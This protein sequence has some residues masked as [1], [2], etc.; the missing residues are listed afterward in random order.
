MGADQLVW[1]LVRTIGGRYTTYVQFWGGEYSREREEL[2]LKLQLQI[3]ET[4][5][6]EY[7]PAVR[8]AV[9]DVSDI[10]IPGGNRELLE[11]AAVF[12]AVLHK[13]EIPIQK[14][15]SN[16]IIKTTAGGE[17]IATVDTEW[18]VSD[19]DYKQERQW[20]DYG[21]C[22]SMW[23]ESGK[24][25]AVSSWSADSRYDCRESYWAN[26]LDTDYEYLY[27]YMKGML[28]E[29][30]T[31]NLTVNPGADPLNSA[32]NPANA[33]KFARL[34]ERGFLTEDG[35]V[36][37]MVIRGSREE[38]F[39]RIP[40]LNDEIKE[41]FADKALEYIMLSA[42]QYPPQ[43]QDLIIARGV[44]GFIGS[45]TA[46]MVMDILYGE[47]VLKPLTEEERVTANLLMF[48]DMLPE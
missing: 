26:N 43:M 22:G 25:R 44:R 31:A 27:E 18:N 41:S 5:V 37:I 19:P 21:V 6:K 42:R 40:A 17:F 15:L 20:P 47:G 3:A 39:A 36:N 48:S 30:P 29:M 38:F 34:R 8:K 28:G 33:E 14:D 10:H 35:K 45:I 2:V 16:Y 7:V 12:Y 13:C 9:E 46:L 4:L 11:A 1:W 32:V 23:R 24:Y